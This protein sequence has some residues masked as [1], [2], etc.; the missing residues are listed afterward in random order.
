MDGI[1]PG[2]RS[3]YLGT[4]AE[5]TPDYSVFINSPLDFEQNVDT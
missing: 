2:R 4:I 3:R 5:I 1:E